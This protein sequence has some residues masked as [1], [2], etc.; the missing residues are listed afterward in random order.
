MKKKVLLSLALLLCLSFLFTQGMSVCYAQELAS[1]KISVYGDACIEVAPDKATIYGVVQAVGG[2]EEDVKTQL[3]TYYQNLKTQL[4]LSDEN[5]KLNGYYFNN[6]SSFGQAVCCGYLNFSIA[7]NTIEQVGEII[8]KAWT[9]DYLKINNI[10]FE[11]SESNAAHSQ[12]LILAVENAK[13]K[14]STLLNEYTDLKVAQII[15][16]NMYCTTGIL[17]DANEYFE[18]NEIVKNVS[19]CARVKVVF[20]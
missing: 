15:E 2:V 8:N 1:P 11:V 17:K 13:N 14:A 4:S 20:E 6:T 3:F 12:A 18:N 5:V 9:L 7:T 19:V 16:E 10:S